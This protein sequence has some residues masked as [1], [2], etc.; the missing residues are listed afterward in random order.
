MNYFFFFFFLSFFSRM[1]L[2][3]AS[4]L[5]CSSF[6]AM[7]SRIITWAYL[8][9]LIL[10]FWQ[11][12]LFVF[13]PMLNVQEEPCLQARGL[14]GLECIKYG[15]SWD[16]LLLLLARIVIVSSD[17][18]SHTINRVWLCWWHEP[19]AMICSRRAY[20]FVVIDIHISKIIRVFFSLFLND[21]FHFHGVA[22]RLEEQLE[23]C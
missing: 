12:L 14:G 18:E 9:L 15:L 13:W 23:L 8:R 7:R 1:A 10:F 2:A 4:L 5:C 3:A 20:F 16:E 22:K 17:S 19:T 11:L 21:F 6:F